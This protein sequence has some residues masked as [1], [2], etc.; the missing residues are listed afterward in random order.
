VHSLRECAHD[1]V[2]CSRV[3]SIVASLSSLADHR[4]GPVDRSGFTGL[5][6]YSSTESPRQTSLSRDNIRG[7]LY[8]LPFQQRITYY[9]LVVWCGV[10]SWQGT[11]LNPPAAFPTSFIFK[12]RLLSSCASRRVL[13]CP[14][15]HRDLSV[16]FTR[17]ISVIGSATW[18]GYPK[19][20]LISVSPTTEDSVSGVTGQSIP[21]A[22]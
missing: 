14:Q 6:R 16:Q 19:R 7:V 9:T 2:N 8:G 12:C 5:Q 18:I 4:L 22:G 13:M 11:I 10:T 17:S 15:V 21:P 20:C 3:S 1:W